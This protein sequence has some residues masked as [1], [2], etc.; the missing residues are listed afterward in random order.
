MGRGALFVLILGAAGQATCP[1][2]GENGVPLV[3]LLPSFGLHTLRLCADGDVVHVEAL[4]HSHPR[5]VL[6]FNVSG[7]PIQGRILEDLREKL[8]PSSKSTPGCE[9]KDPEQCWRAAMGGDCEA[10]ETHRVKCP[11][12]CRQCT[13]LEREWGLF[14]RDGHRGS[15]LDEELTRISRC[16]EGAPRN[17]VASEGGV[18]LWPGVEPGFEQI[19][20]VSEDR[21]VTLTTLSLQPLIYRVRGFLSSEE[22]DHIVGKGTQKGLF[23]S[24]ISSVDYGSSQDAS[25]RSSQ[26]VWLEAEDAI[27]KAVD[28]RALSLLRLP[29]SHMEPTQVLLYEPGQRYDGHHDFFPPDGY[30]NQPQMMAMLDGGR[31]N[32]MATL[33]WYLSDVEEGGETFFPFGNGT[34]R[35]YQNYRDYSGG[36]R[37]SARRGDAVLFYSMLGNGD[38]DH[39]SLHAGLA[40]EKGV[41]W[42]ANKWFWNEPRR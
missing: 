21:N 39:T 36:L 31:R 42:S 30:V 40:V 15:V 35:Y 37:V 13:A 1:L 9:D 3:T 24:S 20:A 6:E 38:L 17:F 18:W 23:K 4:N 7:P 11:V 26:Q 34:R 2:P 5:L 19:V 16:G 41:K 8:R 12:V 25:S 10:S 14:T 28:R 29:A 32:R 33:F 22:A 27:L